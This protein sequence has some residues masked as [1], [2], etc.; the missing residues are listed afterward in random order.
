MAINHEIEGKFIVNSIDFQKLIRHFKLEA[1]KASVQTNYYF[2]TANHVLLHHHWAMRVRNYGTH[3]ELTIKSPLEEGLQEINEIITP[4]EFSNLSSKHIIPK[5]TIGD[6]L[7]SIGI[8]PNDVNNVAT[9]T[10][11]RR[12]LMYLEGELFFDESH[13]NGIIDYEIE[14]E[15]KDTLEAANAKLIELFKEVGI[16]SYNKSESKMRRAILSKRA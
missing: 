9:L 6:K 15:V 10:T 13:Y 11:Y 2:D 8:N 1:V 5:D 4:E 12:S 7:K 3:F 16:T 14:Y